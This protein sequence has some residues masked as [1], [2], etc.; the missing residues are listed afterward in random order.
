[1]IR[2]Y[3]LIRNSKKQENV[4]NFGTLFVSCTGM[5]PV[6]LV[7]VM[8]NPSNFLH[9]PNSVGIVPLMLVYR[10]DISFNSVNVPIP[11]GIV[12]VISEPSMV[13]YPK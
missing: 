9:K 6:I 7:F 1:M 11:V 3:R 10:I 2:L 5:G 8:V 12:P 4:H 13:R